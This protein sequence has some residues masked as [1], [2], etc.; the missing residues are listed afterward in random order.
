MANESK[1]VPV[2]HK[3]ENAILH[4]FDQIQEKIRKRAYDFFS[5]RGSEHGDSIGDWLRAES[6]VLT[7]VSLKPIETEKEFVVEGK[8]DGFKPEEIEVKLENHSLLVTGH[9]SESSE[10]ESDGTMSSTTQSL[11]FYQRFELPEGIDRDHVDAS[12]KRNKLRI[13][14]PKRA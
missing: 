5:D 1:N 3:D 12:V 6:E 9:H 8:V 13:A 11:S 4:T 2:V 7:N 14:I 10:H